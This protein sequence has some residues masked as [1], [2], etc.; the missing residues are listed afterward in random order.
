MQFES[1]L[2]AVKPIRKG[3]PVGYGGRWRARHDTTLGIMAAGYGDGFTRYLASGTP[4]LVNGRPVPLAGTISMDMAAVD[5]GPD[6]RD[7]IGDRVLLWGDAL[8]VEE[9][10]RRAGAFAY[11][12]VCG[13]MHR[14]AAGVAG[15]TGE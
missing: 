2:L 5:L 3:Q 4:V 7:R 9:T 1:C 15:A 12:L 8:P 6:A 14:A 13:V 11:Q 10:A